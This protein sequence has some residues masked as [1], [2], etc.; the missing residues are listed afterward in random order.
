LEIQYRLQLQPD[1]QWL[2][3]MTAAALATIVSGPFNL[4]RN[5]QYATKS[6]H[7]ADTVGKV[8]QDFVQETQ[9]RP[10]LVGKIKYIQSRL[11]I[12]WGTVRVAVGMSFGHYIYDKMMG[13]YED[14]QFLNDA[15]KKKLNHHR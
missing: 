15:S 10:S 14:K 2:A 7:V 13:Y 9:S 6:R 1:Q 3:N 5:V 12:G 11:R 8:L 4:A